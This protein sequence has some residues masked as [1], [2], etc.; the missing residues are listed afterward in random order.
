MK[1]LRTYKLYQHH[2][3]RYNSHLMKYLGTKNIP[4]CHE[5]RDTW[6][7]AYLMKYLRTYKLYQHHDT[8]YNAH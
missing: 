7:N 8:R 5:R 4:L 2:D 3:S 1:Y 6:Y